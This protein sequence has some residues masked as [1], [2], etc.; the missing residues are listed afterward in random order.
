MVTN[1]IIPTAFFGLKNFLDTFAA[2]N[3]DSERVPA[4]ALYEKDGDFNLEIELPGV[5]KEDIEIKAEAGLL[6]VKATRKKGESVWNYKREFRLSEE[7]DQENVKAT[8]ENGV[9]E[10]E[11]KKKE[12]AATKTI[13]IL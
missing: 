8:F 1:Q 5:R 11:L 13:E 10:L 9:L 3:N 7:V 2:D 4:A 6:T 12:Q